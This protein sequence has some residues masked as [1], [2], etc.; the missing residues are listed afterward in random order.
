[1]WDDGE[2]RAQLNMNPNRQAVLKGT[3]YT[4][5]TLDRDLVVGE[6][7][8]VYLP[9]TEN[10]ACKVDGFTPTKVRVRPVFSNAHGMEHYPSRVVNY[11]DVYYVPVCNIRVMSETPVF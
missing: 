8:E 10:V 1:M 4:F 3:N 2:T 5:T 11:T 7:V 6:R 9:H